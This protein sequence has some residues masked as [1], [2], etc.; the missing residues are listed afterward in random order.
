MN[1]KI[2]PTNVQKFD[3]RNNEFCGKYTFMNFKYNFYKNTH[4][5]NDIYMTCEIYIRVN[6]IILNLKLSAQKQQNQE[7]VL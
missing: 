3:D 4:I 6:R 2:Y 5:R 7:Y 1:A